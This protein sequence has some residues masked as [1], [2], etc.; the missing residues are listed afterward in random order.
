MI[1]LGWTAVFCL[2]ALLANASANPPV[3]AQHQTIWTMIIGIVAG[4]AWLL[5]VLDGR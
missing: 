4:F 2:L 3:L 1:V 5:L